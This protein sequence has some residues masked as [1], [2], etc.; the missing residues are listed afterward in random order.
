M[1]KLQTKTELS[2]TL[3]Q[4]R[5]NN[6]A[7]TRN[8]VWRKVKKN[9]VIYSI[10]YC[11]VHTT[12]QKHAHPVK[13]QLWER[14]TLFNPLPS[15]AAEATSQNTTRERRILPSKQLFSLQSTVKSIIIKQYRHAGFVLFFFF[16]LALEGLIKDQVS[17]LKSFPSEKVPM[18]S[19]LFTKAKW[20]VY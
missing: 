8:V 3:S 12:L 13:N 16:F 11:R 18:V 9:S 15:S 7:N 20:K 19:R 4:Q 2:V 14:L 17:S 6:N 5:S 10:M 1:H